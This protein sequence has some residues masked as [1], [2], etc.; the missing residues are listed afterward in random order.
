MCL[1]DDLQG[2]VDGFYTIMNYLNIIF[3]LYSCYCYISRTKFFTPE[4]KMLLR[5]KTCLMHK[6]RLNETNS[7]TSIVRKSIIDFNTVSFKGL[8]SRSGSQELWSNVRKI[9][10]KSKSVNDLGGY[11]IVSAE[12]L[13]AH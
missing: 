4:I 3:T 5:K 10:G 13:N 7:I 9:T 6:G 11:S 1:I 8:S 2:A 12:Q